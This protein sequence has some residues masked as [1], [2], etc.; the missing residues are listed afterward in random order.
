[1]RFSRAHDFQRALYEDPELINAWFHLFLN[2]R[3]KCGILDCDLYKFDE[4][5]FMMG[6]I[7]P[8]MVITRSD[9]RGKSKTAQPENREWTT[10]LPASVVTVSTSPHF[11]S[12]KAPTTWPVGT[13]RV[14]FPARGLSSPRL[15]GGQK[16]RQA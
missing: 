15:M 8:S 5:G 14:I 13:P 7:C 9:R 6:V 2:M 11:C 12:S 1:M 3:N 10:T 16:T 4:T